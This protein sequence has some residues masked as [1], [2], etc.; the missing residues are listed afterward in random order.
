MNAIVKPPL[1]QGQ[2][3]AA[4]AF[5]T[6]LFTEEPEFIIS[7]PGG[8]GKTYLMGQLIDEV[9][10]RYF[11]ACK[12]LNIKPEY[13]S[14]VMCATTNKAAEALGL[15]TGRP[16]QTIHSLMNLKVVDDYKTGQ[17]KI[18]K[19]MGWMVHERKIIF[20]D[21]CSMVDTP[22][23]EAI[24]EGTHKCKIVYVGDHCQMAPVMESLSPIYRQGL[25]QHRLT[26]PMRNSGQTDLIN[27]CNQIRDTVE[28]GVFKPIQTVPGIIDW[29]DPVSMQQELTQV[30]SNQ[31]HN[32]R[33][34]A[35]TN[36]QV[37]AYN[38][39]IR[40]VR[41]L[42]AE[43][44]VGERLINNNAIQM[45]K[46]MLRIEEEVRVVYQSSDTE[47][48]L[49]EPGVELEVRKTD[50]VT[51]YNETLKD[52][53]LPVDREYFDA[54]VRYY[55]RNKNW[56]KYFLLKNKIPDLRQRDAS[57]VYKAQGSTLDTVYIDAAN[58]STCTN[59][60]QAARM[61]YVAVSRAR[62][63]I[64]FYGSLAPKYGGLIS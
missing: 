14:V 8:V 55:K 24:R 37:V 38:Q 25:T 49:V 27:L 20:I 52:M 60:D 64:V 21:E 15:A 23:H 4:E 58:I 30:F 10:P 17:S 26:E 48:F 54:L 35:Y 31:E 56:H 3:D 61:L 51:N 59:A 41:Q 40:E 44:T 22:L 18:T 39:F 62:K 33:I 36:N 5:F 29:L 57:T 50:L 28:T 46:R 1:N 12:L 42:P 13:D 19:S 2:R 6:F 34:L 63:R 45:K 47:P 16:T 32:N 53:L 7:G 11:D 9:L 43:F